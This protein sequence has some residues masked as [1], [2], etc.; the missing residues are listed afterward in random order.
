MDVTNDG[1]C[2]YTTTAKHALSQ[3]LVSNADAVL[4]LI[5]LL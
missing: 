2:A 5:H 4:M 3:H 1:I